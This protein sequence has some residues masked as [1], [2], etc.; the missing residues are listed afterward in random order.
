M[1]AA[2]ALIAFTAAAALTHAASATVYFTFHDPSTPRELEYI[3]GDAFNSGSITYDVT[4][5]VNL[6]VDG[7]EHGMG[8]VTYSSTLV[9][10]LSVSTASGAFGVFTSFI[11]GT[12][13]FVHNGEDILTG[14]IDDGALIT[15]ATSGAMI[16][17]SSN[18]SLDLVAGGALLAALNAVSLTELVP[19]FDAS[20]SL[21]DINPGVLALNQ[22]GY[23]PSFRANVAFVGNA[24]VIPSPGSTA[25]G[26]IA[27]A[28]CVPGRRRRHTTAH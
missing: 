13:R 3:A 27:A 24:E 20:F 10:D 23:M 16:A 14:Y 5:F 4:K 12:F 25:L 6:I 1:R 8:V 15:F 19:Q 9:L 7:S 28:F 21:A 22:F 18:G 2:H 11:G 17:T 26:A